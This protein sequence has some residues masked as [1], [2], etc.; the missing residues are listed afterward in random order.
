MAKTEN[1]RHMITLP[2]IPFSVNI[3]D[4]VFGSHSMALSAIRIPPNQC[5]PK[6]QKATK[7]VHFTKINQQLLQHNY[8]WLEFFLFPL[9][10]LQHTNKVY[11]LI[12]KT[13]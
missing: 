4:A 9:L 7:V 2:S 12:L 11:V 8:L 3:E 10:L 6:V 1:K 5:H 13:I